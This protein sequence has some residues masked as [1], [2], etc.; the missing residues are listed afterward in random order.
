MKDFTSNSYSYLQVVLFQCKIRN[1]SDFAE[2]ERLV[3]QLLNDEVRANSLKMVYT[4]LRD[5]NV[6]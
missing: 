5:K 2:I 4:L 6:Y 1:N 3:A